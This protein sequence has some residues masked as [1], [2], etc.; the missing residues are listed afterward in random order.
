MY[1]KAATAAIAYNDNDCN[2]C[3]FLNNCPQSLSCISRVPA[4]DEKNM[5]NKKRPKQSKAPT[6][7]V[8]EPEPKVQGEVNFQDMHSNKAGLIGELSV[9]DET[10][11]KVTRPKSRTY[12]VE[13]TITREEVEQKHKDLLGKLG[14]FRHTDQKG[15]ADQINEILPEEFHVLSDDAKN[16]LGV[17]ATNNNRKDL[18]ERVS[19]VLDKDAETYTGFIT[20]TDPH[21]MNWTCDPMY[22]LG[23]H[24]HA[25]AL[26]STD[27]YMYVAWTA[28]GWR[29]K[30]GALYQSNYIEYLESVN[31]KLRASSVTQMDVKGIIAEAFASNRGAV[32]VEGNETDAPVTREDIEKIIADRIA[33]IQKK[34]E[35]ERKE[36]GPL[37]TRE[38]IERM[39]KATRENTI[40]A[41]GQSEPDRELYKFSHEVARLSGENKRLHE[42][43]DRLHAENQHLRAAAKIPDVSDERE[44]RSRK[45]GNNQMS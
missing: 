43:N 33:S 5:S 31:E 12:E 26:K 42:D 40:K 7:E 14:S 45:R 34:V 20:K 8:E 10:R 11:P 19:Q 35:D 4:Q 15:L 2:K 36:F 17:W 1:E 27:S 41:S 25:L 18:I 21:I 39:M 9:F 22:E 32:N 37:A 44:L 29:I 13:M 16:K 28:M 38:D 3:F 6:T 23:N 30:K 24:A